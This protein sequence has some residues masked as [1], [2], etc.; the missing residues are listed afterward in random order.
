MTRSVLV[1]GSSRG[2]GRAIALQLA[3]QGFDVVLH[4]RSQRASAE[5]VREQIMFLFKTA[6]K[7]ALWFLIH[8]A[9][10]QTL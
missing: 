2:I 3:T 6:L 4:C 1:T 5:Q 8:Q 9:L 7:K 10:M